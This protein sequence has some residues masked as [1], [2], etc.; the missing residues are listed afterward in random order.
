MSS[1]ENIAVWNIPYISTPRPHHSCAYSCGSVDPGACGTDK[2]TD[3]FA[4]PFSAS[5]NS[6]AGPVPVVQLFTAWSL[7]NTARPRPATRAAG[8]TTATVAGGVTGRM[9]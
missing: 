1:L 5:Q 3:P 2:G 4:T 8:G 9:H 7:F 6:T